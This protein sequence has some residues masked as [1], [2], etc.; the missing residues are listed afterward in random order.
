MIAVRESINKAVHDYPYIGIGT[1]F[2]NNPLH[3]H[4]ELEFL[5]VNEG[6]IL[7]VLESKTFL[8]K[9]GDIC[10]VL[11][12]KIHTLLQSGQI[13][14]TVIKLLPAEPLFG[15]CLSP[16][17]L[18]EQIPLY[19]A[20]KAEI[21]RIINEDREKKIGYR[22]AVKHACDALTLLV[23]RGALK[24]TAV[25]DFEEKQACRLLLFEKA[26]EYIKKN[27]KNEISLDRV[28]S[29]FGYSRSY[30]SRLFKS[31]CG[32]GFFD[33]LSVF[34]LKKSTEL[35]MDKEMTIEGVALA[36]GFHCLRSYNRAFFKYFGQSPGA[37]RRKFL[38][39]GE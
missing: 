19:S 25:E 5:Y 22:L 31:V 33:Y 3:F 10:A 34:R 20:M 18:C 11:P 24:D 1:H 30:F 37:Y 16:C 27:Y 6:E 28:A 4:A 12:G 38:S 8:L 15:L 29:A 21:E 13:K 14:I 7:A 35:L 36:S 23:L 39:R 26:N 2:E 32:M 9:K 17:V